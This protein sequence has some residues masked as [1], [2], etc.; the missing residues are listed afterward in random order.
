MVLGNLARPRKIASLQF[1]KNAGDVDIV[2]S[3]I[4]AV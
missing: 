3:L 4:G 2:T 1:R